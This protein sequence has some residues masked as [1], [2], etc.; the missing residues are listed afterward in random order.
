MA[1]DKK[2]LGFGIHG[3]TVRD[4]FS[5]LPIAELD[6]VGDLTLPVTAET[7]ALFG[8][9][10]VWP[11]AGEPKTIM[12]EGSLELR[13][14]PEEIAEYFVAG[15][16]VKTA[17]SA[18]GAVTAPANYK[19]TSAMSATTGVASAGI[20]TGENANLKAGQYIGV[21]VTASTV[22]IYA[23]TTVDAKKG[24]AYT[25]QGDNLKITATPLTIATTTPV[26]IPNTGIEL[27]GGSGTIGMTVGD[28]FYFEVYPPHA[29]VETIT[30]GQEG[31]AFKRVALTLAAQK[32]T[33]GEIGYIECP[34]A[35]CLGLP[36]GMSEKGWSGGGVDIKIFTHETFDFAMKF[37]SI[38][39]TTV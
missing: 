29:G 2:Q 10:H 15:V 21:V 4:Y 1:K 26:E 24:T 12:S 18:T 25:V 13:E 17:A 19:G 38:K 9:S 39:G 8:G 35:L 37:T 14:Y 36:I 20:K 30:M 34:N 31:A 16:G 27:T 23:T 28:T 7:E 11:V 6:V 32:R 3:V 33:T 22:D 5:G